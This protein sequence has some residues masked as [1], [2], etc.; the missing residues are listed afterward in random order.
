MLDASQASDRGEP[1]EGIGEQAYVALPGA[2]LGVVAFVN[3]RLSVSILVRSP[4]RERTALL[5]LAGVAARR[6]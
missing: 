4:T 1:V 2:D 3:G 6:A 5:D